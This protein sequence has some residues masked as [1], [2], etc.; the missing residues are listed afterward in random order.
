VGLS[1]WR[2]LIIIA[3]GSLTILVLL[4]LF[5][6]TVVIGLSVRALLGAVRTLLHDEVTPL[7]TQGR[8]TVRRVQGTAT[9]ISENAAGPVIRVYGAVAG[10]RRLLGVLSGVS[11]KR[12]KRS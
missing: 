8:Q 5:V 10:G 4:A 12:K 6:F 2:D 11:G 3:A 7:L 1:D 9:F